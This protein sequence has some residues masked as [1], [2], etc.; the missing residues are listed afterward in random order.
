MRT[1]SQIEASRI[2]GA[3]SHGPVTE[4]GKAVSSRNATRHGILSK[5]VIL[6]GESADR[7]QE[8]MAAFIEQFDPGDSE[9]LSLVEHMAVCRW[10][11][12]SVWGLET[13][14]ISDA[15]RELTEKSPDLLEKEPAVR[16]FRAIGEMNAKGNQLDTLLRYDVRF[17][18]QFYRAYNKL[19]EKKKIDFA[20]RTQQTYE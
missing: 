4:E 2:N 7:F 12:F 8:H 3:K 19:R 10:R 15:I 16:A 18:R 1:G 20:K 6:E 17:D 11:Q 9:E 5:T 14:G 13:A